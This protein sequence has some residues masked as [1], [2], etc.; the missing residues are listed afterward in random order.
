MQR[1]EEMAYARQDGRAEGK[2]EGEDTKLIKLICRKLQKNKTP[3]QIAEDLEE[4]L[5][6]IQL[7][8]DVAE[9]CAP[10]YDIEKIYE[11]YDRIA[12]NRLIN[13]SDVDD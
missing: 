5:D 12:H 1:W 8:C 7:I 4:E 11:K 10:V 6:V 3:E 13:C 9:D 2:A